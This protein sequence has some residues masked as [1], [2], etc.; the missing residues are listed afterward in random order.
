MKSVLALALVGLTTFGCA[1]FGQANLPPRTEFFVTTGDIGGTNYQPVALVAS[2]R[3][4]CA[5]CGLSL[6]RAY[7]KIEE[8]LKQ[9]LIDKAKAFGANGIINM[10][11]RIFQGPG[12]STVGAQGM[13]V[14]F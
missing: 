11:V 8:S 10:S 9:D 3:T 5:P 2:E 7:Q 4:L 12:L 13:A 14:R 6:E 1:S